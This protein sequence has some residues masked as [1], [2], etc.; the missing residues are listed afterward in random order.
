MYIHQAI[1]HI[2]DKDA[3]NLF[4]SQEAMDLSSPLIRTYLDKLLTKVQKAEPLS[5]IHI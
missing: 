3:G 4:L 5:L 1:L 2:L